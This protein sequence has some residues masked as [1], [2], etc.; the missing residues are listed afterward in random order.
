MEAKFEAGGP[1]ERA[2]AEPLWTEATV[3][4]GLHHGRGEGNGN[5]TEQ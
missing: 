4:G 1:A 5:L 3:P 2:K